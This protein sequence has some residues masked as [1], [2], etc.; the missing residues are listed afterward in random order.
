M[1]VLITRPVERLEAEVARLREENGVTR[2]RALQSEELALSVIDERDALRAKLERVK[3]EC[4]GYL[5]EQESRDLR[6]HIL[7][8][9][10]ED[11]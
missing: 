9:L 6:R 10:E 11:K 7:N 8:I 2:E 5:F 3:A 4:D 1:R